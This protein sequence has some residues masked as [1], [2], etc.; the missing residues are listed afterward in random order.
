MVNKSTTTSGSTANQ[1]KRSTTN[2]VKNAQLHVA[3]SPSSARIRIM[4]I[5]PKFV[6][7]IEL[8]AGRYHIE[9]TAPGYTKYLKWIT[10][11]P[12]E[13]RTLPIPLTKKG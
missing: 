7:G 2:Q 13:V 8:E 11:E 1:V 9:V 4:N 6:Q 10:L 5:N 12:G 3:P